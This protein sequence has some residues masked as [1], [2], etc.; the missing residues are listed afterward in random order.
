[1]A[2]DPTR[3]DRPNLSRYGNTSGPNLSRYGNANL[4]RYGN[5]NSPGN[6]IG[7]PNNNAFN[8]ANN[9]GAYGMGGQDGGEQI[10][11]I[12]HVVFKRKKLIAGLFLAV[13]L[14]GLV[15][16]VL[17][18]PSY[19]ASAM[20]M[21]SSKRTDPELQPTDM[22]RLEDIKLNESLVNTEVHVLK[23]RDLVERVVRELVTKEDGTVQVKANS[24]GR[25]TLAMRN[26]LVVT[27][28]KGSN[29]IRIDYKS[30]REEDAAR[31]VNLMVDEYLSYHA[32]V[33][34]GTAR[35][36]PQFYESQK[37]DLEKQLR[38]A[39]QALLDFTY[40]TGLV[41]PTEEIGLTMRAQNELRGTLREVSTSIAGVEEGL[42]VLRTQIAEQPELVKQSQAIE[43]SPT[44]KQLSTHL[45]DRQMDRVDLRRR[46]TDEDRLVRDNA[47]EIAELEQ[48]LAEE[49]ATRPTVVA[50]ELIR[51][52]PLRESLLR[53]LLEKESR[54]QELRARQ[55]TLEE[56]EREVGGRL[57][58][59]RKDAMQYD[60]LQQEVKHQRETYQ[61]YLTRAQ[62][63]KISLAM[64]DANLV[65]VEVVQRPGLPL[66]RADT[67]QVTT[68]LSLIAGLLVGLAGAFG[69]EYMSRSLR[70]EFDVQRH[71]GLPLLAS[72]GDIDR[73]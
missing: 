64:D 16:T 53:E 32:E 70:T 9:Q 19:M 5:N 26:K 27:P 36:L 28:V 67:Q 42:E 45:L 44:V 73:R 31:V 60:R 43:T 39:E 34:G 38:A 56:E 61:L 21:I 59:L 50:N 35:N 47:E 18:K 24:L 51:I 29:V 37:R 12:L 52:N 49:V 65:N 17:Q 23:S 57:L 3:H 1:M 33:H 62:E 7:V 68:T 63:A 10:R 46:Y 58:Q 14:P 25:Q 72:I 22:T 69:R 6:N 4:S 71:L 55:V 54:L 15:T 41:S 40:E 30:A 2:Y 11:D 66:P 13:A 48:Q 8:N 20:V